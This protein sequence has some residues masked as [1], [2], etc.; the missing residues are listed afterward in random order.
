MSKNYLVVW[1]KATCELGIDNIDYQHKQLVD[2]INELAWSIDNNQAAGIISTLFKKLY[3]YTKFHFKAE[4][5]YFC[6][7]NKGD[8][9]LHQLQH[10]HFIE[11]LDRII[12]LEKIEIISKE[13]LF[14]LTDWLVSHIQVEDKKFLK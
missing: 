8:L 7:L 6:K 4:E 11:E 2:Y 9:L 14:F 3:D 13:L 12:A 1:D 5:A 10:K